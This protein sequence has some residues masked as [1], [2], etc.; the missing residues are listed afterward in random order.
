MLSRVTRSGWRVGRRWTSTN[1]PVKKEEKKV[2]Y[3]D[4]SRLFID[5][6]QIDPISA[7]T[8][9]GGVQTKESKDPFFYSDR[10]GLLSFGRFSI[11]SF[12]ESGSW[13]F[14]FLIF[15]LREE[16]VYLASIE[17]IIQFQFRS[18]DWTLRIPS[19]RFRRVSYLKTF[20]IFKS[21]KIYIHKWNIFRIYNEM[22]AQFKPQAGELK[23]VEGA[24]S[25]DGEEKDTKVRLFNFLKK[26]RGK[27]F[28]FYL[29]EILVYL[30]FFRKKRKR[31]RKQRMV[32]VR[33]E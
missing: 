20:D 25:S 23:E 29:L 12:Q 31:R 6:L 26:L 3:I 16:T 24:E 15:D 2:R 11:I 5:W 18:C 28:R 17:E 22:S 8:P 9:F 4:Y 30:Y 21:S 19:I 10:Y 32:S 7:Y 14:S 13:L 27:F 33:G 1:T